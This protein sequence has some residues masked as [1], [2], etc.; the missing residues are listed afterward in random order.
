MN[1]EET[2]AEERL[3]SILRPSASVLIE[4]SKDKQANYKY[5]KIEKYLSMSNKRSFDTAMRKLNELSYDGCKIGGV[6]TD[7]EW[8]LIQ[9]WIIKDEFMPYFSIDFNTTDKEVYYQYLTALYI[10][11]KNL[12]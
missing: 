8:G 1:L 10:A 2:E 12:K 4:K 7:A 9:L 11:N 5:G 3:S 6:C